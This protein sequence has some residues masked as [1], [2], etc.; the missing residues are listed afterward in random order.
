MTHK[1]EYTPP[2]ETTP[3]ILDYLM[4]IGEKLGEI[5]VLHA[6]KISPKLRRI[7]RIRTIHSILAI[8]HN[9]LSLEQVTAI[10]SGKRIL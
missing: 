9:T 6:D 1:I 3:I 7:N 10:I 5:K 4:Q 8:E 2:Y